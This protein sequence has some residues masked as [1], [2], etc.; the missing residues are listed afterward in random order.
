[1]TKHL[2]VKALSP[3][4]SKP[5]AVARGGECQAEPAVCRAV[6]RTGLSDVS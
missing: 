2:E 5:T 4:H 1:M 6:V 3:K